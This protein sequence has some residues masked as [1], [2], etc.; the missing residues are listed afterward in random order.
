MTAISFLEN[1]EFTEDFQVL[2]LYETYAFMLRAKH[3]V[4]AVFN[5]D[6]KANMKIS[7]PSNII[8]QGKPRTV[9][10][11]MSHLSL[12]TINVMS[13]F[14]FYYYYYFYFSYT[15]FLYNLLK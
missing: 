5:Q 11:C 15:S 12:R 14:S 2:Q 8:L 13:L 3:Q 9:C 6:S 4:Q 10:M 1:S 7:Q